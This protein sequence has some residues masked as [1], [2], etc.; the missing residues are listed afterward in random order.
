MWVALNK[1]NVI[2]ALSEHPFSMTGYNVVESD[3]KEP[4]D[5]WHSL[6]GKKFNT[7]EPK[8]VKDLKIAFICN[9]NDS[10]GIST[11][12]GFLA[13]SLISK[14]KEFRVFSEEGE[15]RTDDPPYVTRC[16]KRGTSLK[17]LID[18]IK[19]WAPD[20]IIIQHEFGIFPKAT[21]FLQFLQGIEDIP[22]VVTLHS[23]YEHLDKAVC[24]AAIKNIVVH[25]EEGKQVL[26]KLG[27]TNE[28]FVVPHGCVEFDPNETT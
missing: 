28:I 25:T 23:V 1:K 20:F 8:E 5:K 19:D 22:Y 3:L 11:Y 12:S 13:D 24:T 7:G 14:V 9:W 4:K 6:V 16:W 21:F 26:K 15:N 18:K 2:V 10:C 27:N 17:N